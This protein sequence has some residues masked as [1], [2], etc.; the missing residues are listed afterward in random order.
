MTLNSREYLR[1]VRDGGSIFAPLAPAGLDARQ[2]SI[3]QSSELHGAAV[4]DEAL[5]RKYAGLSAAT[6]TADAPIDLSAKTLTAAD[7]PRLRRI[8]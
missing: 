6:L 5:P 1:S 8:P 2:T 7:G 3:G 4:N